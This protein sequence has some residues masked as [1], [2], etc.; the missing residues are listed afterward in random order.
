M[1]QIVV[2]TALQHGKAKNPTHTIAAKTGT[3][4]ISQENGGG[5]YEDRYLHS[6]FGYFPVKDPRFLVFFFSKHPIGAQYASETL[7]DPFMNITQFLINYYQIPP[8]RVAPVP[9]TAQ[10]KS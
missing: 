2:D 1:L 9:E 5:Y 3:A 6:F 4:Q 8:D 7:T 10:K